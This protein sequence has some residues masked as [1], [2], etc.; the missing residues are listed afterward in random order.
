[1]SELVGRA[2]IEVARE[3]IG[4]ALRLTPVIDA[5]SL[6]D[7]LGRRT[8]L[9]AENLQRTGSFKPRGAL[10]V[11]GSLDD[12]VTE[13]VAASAGN[14]AQGLAMAARRAGRRATV[15][16]PATASLPKVEATRGYG[17]EVVLGGETVDDAIDAARAE[18]SRTGARFVS[19]FDDR[20]VIAGQG[21]LGL[22]LL[23]Q[24]DETATVLV[25]VGGGG[26]LSG[27]AA[28]LRADGRAW[29]LLGVE[30]AGAASM[31]AS[32]TA[33]RPTAI[34]RASTI[35][36]GIALKSPSELTLRHTTAL[37]DDVVA[38]TEEAIAAALLLVLER[39]R[40][41]VEPAAAV[42]IAAVLEGLVPGDGPVVAVLSGGNVDSMLLGHLVDHGLSVAGR[43]LRIRAVVPDRPGGLSEVTAATADLGVNVVDVEHHRAGA[44]VGIQ[45]V[46]LLMTVETRDARHGEELLTALRR[47][48]F[49]VD[50][51]G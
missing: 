2:E 17:A 31:V 41:V 25:P 29:S 21:T 49:E 35:A 28:A 30:A 38:V 6:G 22:E 10:S 42:G 44:A 46:E 39:A 15:F 26:L 16:M 37:V 27:V 8:L 45:R 50:R 24:V 43:F 32:L 3:R 48:G 12:T 7:R 14:H 13:V 18:A 23:E 51:A 36:D 5:V 47:R 40:L 20:L 1:M 9:K 34:E 33:G 19:P 4:D 11:M